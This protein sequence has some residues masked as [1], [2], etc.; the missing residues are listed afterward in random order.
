MNAMVKDLP[1]QAMQP[2]QHAQSAT[3]ADLVRYAIDSGADLDRLE[4]LMSMQVQ[5]EERQARQAYVA[6]MAEFKASP[7]TIMKDKHVSFGT[8]SGTTAYDHATIGNVTTVICAALAKCG[9]SHRW[10]VDQRD[11]DQIQVTCVITHALG[12]SESTT[13]RAG[14][15]KSGGKNTIQSM[16][17]TVT[18]LQRYTLL[19]ATGMAT[20]DQP[21]DDGRQ[22]PEPEFDQAAADWIAVAEAIADLPEHVAKKADV[23]KHYGCTE[24]VPSAVIAAFRSAHARLTKGAGK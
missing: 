7:L 5:W 10:D 20:S 12:H 14:A 23:I 6:A 13:L 22:P 19:A 8:G 24:K 16:A 9:F 21:D 17:S 1:A 2:K 4:K 11:G 3:P 18:Y 15:D